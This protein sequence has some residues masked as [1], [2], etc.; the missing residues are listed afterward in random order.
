MIIF[1]SGKNIAELVSNIKL[2]DYQKHLRSKR[3]QAKD[4]DM[5][6]Y[7]CAISKNCVATLD[8][9]IPILLLASLYNWEEWQETFDPVKEY[10][11]QTWKNAL[12]M[13]WLP[14]WFD[15]F[16]EKNDGD[17]S[18]NHKFVD[19]MK[20]WA[21]ADLL[22]KEALTSPCQRILQCGDLSYYYYYYVETETEFVAFN[23][24]LT[25]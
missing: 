23:S 13:E 6:A 5:G 19:E 17:Y 4:C 16:V 11:L 18:I 1:E 8:K 14:M 3:L 12:F 2:N 21:T 22:M 15:T 24:W 10:G 9:A 20:H 25:D 7:Y